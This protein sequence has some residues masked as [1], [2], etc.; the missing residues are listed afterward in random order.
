[1]V[2]TRLTYGVLPLGNVGPADYYEF[3]K[4]ILPYLIPYIRFVPR[5]GS[6]L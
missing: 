4:V 1:M 6:A 3:I 2:L 5:R